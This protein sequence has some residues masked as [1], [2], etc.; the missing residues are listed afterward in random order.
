VKDLRRLSCKAYAFVEDSNRKKLDP[1]AE[2]GYLIGYSDV[3]K[4]YRIW[5]PDQW[6]IIEKSSVIF[7]ELEVYQKAKEMVDG[8]ENKEEMKTFLKRRGLV[9]KKK[10]PRR[11][12]RT[13]ARMEIAR[14]ANERIQDL[15]TFADAL[16]SAQKK[17]LD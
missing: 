4:G 11:S 12:K 9:L 2:E 14:I 7:D 1:K 13:Q 5:L 6:K 16:Q 8:E 3:S 15:K 17:G 10:E